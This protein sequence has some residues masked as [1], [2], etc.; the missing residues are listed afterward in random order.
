MPPR[1]RSAADPWEWLRHARSNLARCRSDR[2][3]PEVLFED[4]CFDAQHAAEKAAKAVLV[5]KG[6]RFAKTHD[7]AELLALVED[8]GVTVPAAVLEA[9]RLT[10]YAVAGRYPGVSEDASEEDHREALAIAEA[11]VGWA[12]KLVDAHFAR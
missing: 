6:R 5:L 4:L 7:L 12:V 8:A 2:S 9:K 10:P 11:V 1:L 3:R